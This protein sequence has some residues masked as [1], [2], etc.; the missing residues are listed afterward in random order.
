MK[1]DSRC[2]E[3]SSPLIIETHQSKGGLVLAS[4][5]RRDIPFKTIWNADCHFRYSVFRCR[6]LDRKYFLDLGLVKF[7]FEIMSGISEYSRRGG[8][9]GRLDSSLNSSVHSY[10][11]YS[12][13]PQHHEN[14]YTT[15]STHNTFSS[16]YT[17]RPANSNLTPK[18]SIR[19]GSYD[20]HYSGGKSASSKPFG[21]VT[22]SYSMSSSYG[23]SGNPGSSGY[24]SR[25]SGGGMSSSYHQDYSSGSRNGTN[26]TGFSTDYKRDTKYTSS[27][28]LN[29]G[30]GRSAGAM[31][32]SFTSSGMTPSSSA[33]SSRV[34]SSTY[35]SPVG[36]LPRRSTSY[37][38][39][40]SFGVG[41]NTT[42]GSRYSISTSRP[43]ASTSGGGTGY[44]I[45]S[46]TPSTDRYQ[47]R[48][49]T[50]LSTYSTRE[51]AT[52]RYD[53]DYRSMGRFETQES[54]SSN[55]GKR[56]EDSVEKTFEK[57]YKKYVQDEKNE[58]KSKEADSVVAQVGNRESKSTGNS[59]ASS[60]STSEQDPPIGKKSEPANPK[61]EES[62]EEE[63]E[64]EELSCDEVEPETTKPTKI[65]I[66]P[67]KPA[68]SQLDKLIKMANFDQDK[69]KSILNTKIAEV[70]AEKERIVRPNLDASLEDANNKN[71]AEK[72]DEPDE[73]SEST[74]TATIKRAQRRERTMEN[75]V[76]QLP[77][78]ATSSNPEKSEPGTD[79]S[80]QQITVQKLKP[81]LLLVTPDSL[82]SSPLST[83]ANIMWPM[84]EKPAE[85]KGAEEFESDWEC[86]ASICR[87]L[88]LSVSSNEGARGDLYPVEAMFRSVTPDY[89]DNVEF[90][91]PFVTQEEHES[92]N[93]SRG[94][95]SQS[96]A[97][98]PPIFTASVS[99]DGM[100]S[101]DSAKD[102]GSLDSLS[103]VDA[104]FYPVSSR[105]GMPEDSSQGLYL[106]PASFSSGDSDHDVDVGCTLTLLQQAAMRGSD[107][108]YTSSEYY[109]SE[110]D[111]VVSIALPPPHEMS[112]EDK[113]A[114]NE[115]N[116]TEEQ[117]KTSVEE[118]SR[119]ER[120][121]S[122]MVPRL[123]ALPSLFLAEPMSAVTEGTTL[124]ETIE[125]ETL[126]MPEPDVVRK[127]SASSPEDDL[128][129]KQK[130]VTKQTTY[131]KPLE[132]RT[133]EERANALN[134]S[135]KPRTDFA[136]KA[137]V[138]PMK[139]EQVK[140]LEQKVIVESTS[141]LEKS[142]AVSKTSPSVSSKTPEPKVEEKKRLEDK[143]SVRKSTLNMTEEE[144]KRADELLKE[145]ARQKARRSGAVS[146]MM[147]RFKEPEVKQEPITYK[148][149]SRLEPKE[150]ARPKRT[151]API[152][153]P[154][155]NDEFDKQMAELRE[156]MKSK[157]TRFQ[158]EYKNLSHGIHSKADEAKLKAMEDKHKTLLGSTSTVFS[159]AE[160]EKKRWREQ[161][162]SEVE[163]KHKENQEKAK[164]RVVEEEKRK[165]QLQQQQMSERK[166]V[167]RR[168][169][170][171]DI[172]AAK[173]KALE[174][175]QKVDET[176]ADSGRKS[177]LKGQ[178]NQPAT[179]A[180]R[181]SI[182]G[183]IGGN[184]HDKPTKRVSIET[185]NASAAEPTPN[186][187][188]GRR[189]SSARRKTEEL[190]NFSLPVTVTP[191][192][193]ETTS[194]EMV[195]PEKAQEGLKVVQTKT[196]L[197]RKRHPNR[198]KHHFIRNPFDIDEFMGWTSYNT[199][200]KLDDFFTNSPREKVKDE[201]QEPHLKKARI[202]ERQKI[203]ISE[204][205]D[206]DKLYK[207]SELRDIRLSAEA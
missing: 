6:F 110:E 11:S 177:S 58:L 141:I 1:Y 17:S 33:V 113:V 147:E 72:S 32:S 200:E 158:S 63:S 178:V 149:S 111:A 54:S 204:L 168:P 129:S 60:S 96:N 81:P 157:S 75:L 4:L 195:D 143:S 70:Q 29:T 107:E 167:V 184:A 125:L 66:R 123:V 121:P 104:G 114:E 150:D 2:C 64:E 12:S 151:Y 87:T 193:A 153:K 8:S 202:I 77:V 206:I 61:K 179:T 159:K 7:L 27:D 97:L 182:D 44:T 84:S 53:R 67:L 41:D 89:L 88:Q 18:P 25:S 30:A 71:S 199:F 194:K 56:R 171:A 127:L 174:E 170:K 186:R 122:L 115:K 140:V 86:D 161:H 203:W 5:G 38:S 80:R 21:K 47:Y 85:E 19:A 117:E 69:F 23:K 24:G 205:R 131:A 83:S 192:G 42:S 145:Q 55:P 124:E 133:E 46:Y 180:Q 79:S 165:A 176:G 48:S 90:R 164:Q 166:G 40:L 136:K 43:N 31:S 134:A 162:E 118:R 106:T 51:P 82:P 196:H 148:R 130:K 126:N 50:P 62:S 94:R 3:R 59:S 128:D 181:P 175:S 142:D 28:R 100:D 105:L 112:V 95:V 22:V 155:I 190:M 189:P 169:R 185:G 163:K 26:S 93:A 135:Q 173:L 10:K 144:R 187:T 197:K 146:A 120:S 76:V 52:S 91:L 73:S 20:S 103:D 172:E 101:W 74:S 13:V 152:V 160:D 98:P 183:G 119:R 34:S 99:Y 198:K 207:F 201:R 35:T 137:V 191:S 37:G 15:P 116:D 139:T 16:S 36:G 102:S 68:T 138:Q 39:G 45:S 57:L 65:E 132:E 92:R 154:V 188:E 109:D 9:V 49:K 108:E 78:P 156:Q 14:K